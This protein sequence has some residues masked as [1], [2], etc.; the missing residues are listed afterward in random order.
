MNRT[1]L[2]PLRLSRFKDSSVNPAGQRARITEYAEDNEDHVI[3]VDVDM[4]VSGAVPIRERPGLGPYLAPDKLP[5]IDGF[6]AD[7]MDRL[8][9]DMLDY[10]QFARDM[11]ALGKIIIDVSDG[12]DTSTDRGR[13][14]LEDRILAA[15]RERERIAGRCR[16]AAERRSNVGRWLGGKPGFR[17]FT[18]LR[19]SW[20]SANAPYQSTTTGWRR[21]QDEEDAATAKWMV[22]QRIAGKG[23]AAIAAE[24]NRAVSPLPVTACRARARRTGASGMLRPLTK[25]LPHQCCS[26]TSS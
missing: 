5:G 23:F 11:A 18:P 17:I 7:E 26:V 15:Q 10:L 19:M 1:L 8:S 16:K 21:V 22:Q 13:Q 4:D 3:F 14:M 24:L 25:S 6:L 9:R 2:A 20:P 12:T